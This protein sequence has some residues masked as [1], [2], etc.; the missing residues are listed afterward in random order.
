MYSTQAIL[1]EL[2]QHFH[3]SPSATD[4]TLSVVVIAVPAGARVWGPKSNR[5]PILRVC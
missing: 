1:P 3:V 5:L 2:G 4:A